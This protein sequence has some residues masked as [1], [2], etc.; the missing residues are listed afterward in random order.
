MI[1]LHLKWQKKYQQNKTR[2]KTIKRENICPD[3][4]DS[5]PVLETSA[6]MQFI[7]ASVL[8]KLFLL[9]IWE[10]RPVICLKQLKTREIYT[11][12]RFWNLFYYHRF[13]RNGTLVTTVPLRNVKCRA[14]QTASYIPCSW[15]KKNLESFYTQCSLLCSYSLFIYAKLLLILLNICTIVRSLAS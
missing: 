11:G 7:P 15:S 4:K 6:M 8:L 10:T 2:L 12:F 14:C 5:H 13:L 9:C 3:V 1:Y